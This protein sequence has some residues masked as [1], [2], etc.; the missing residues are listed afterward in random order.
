MLN[1][2]IYYCGGIRRE[3]EFRFRFSKSSDYKYFKWVGRW[4][5]NIFSTRV[6]SYLVSWGEGIRGRFFLP[7]FFLN[8][9][10]TVSVNF[11]R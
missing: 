11:N 10:K 4:S 8:S 1:G 7:E 6:S 2:D 9:V 3:R 5:E